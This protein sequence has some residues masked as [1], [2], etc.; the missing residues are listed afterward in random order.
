MTGLRAGNG[1][2]FV[3]GSS[4]GLK[5]NLDYATIA[6]AAATGKQVWIA[7]YNG[8]ANRADEA[9]GLIV[10]LG[11]KLVIV[12]GSSKGATTGFDFATVAYASATGKQV[13]ARRYNGPGNMAD[14]A[15]G[16]ALGPGGRTMFVAGLSIS[17]KRRVNFGTV[18][19][20]AATGAPR[21][22]ATFAGPGGRAQPGPIAAS[23]AGRQVFVGGFAGVNVRHGDFTELIDTVAYQ[24]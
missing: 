2:V 13:W 6:Y 10:G 11:G 14:L 18:S 19:Y 9:T 24:A 12:T 1:F 8:P 20:N 4:Q 16:I 21:W 7:R 17:S 22:A 5:S 15:T 3:T 23:P